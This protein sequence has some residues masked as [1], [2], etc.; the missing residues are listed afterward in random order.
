VHHKNISVTHKKI[1]HIIVEIMWRIK[2]MCH[3]IEAFCA[4]T[5]VFEFFENF[6]AHIMW[7]RHKNVKILLRT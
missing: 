3:R 7:M 2:N 5:V 6:V 1:L 4:A